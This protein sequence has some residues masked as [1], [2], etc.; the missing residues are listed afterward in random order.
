MQPPTSL[1]ALENGVQVGWAAGHSLFEVQRMMPV[2]VP[3]ATHAA[4]FISEA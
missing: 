1:P 4:L 2:H 3:A